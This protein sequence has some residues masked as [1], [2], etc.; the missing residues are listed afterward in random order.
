MSRRSSRK[1]R[2][3]KFNWLAIILLIV[4]VGYFVYREFGSGAGSSANAPV[5]RIDLPTIEPNP[6]S[7]V[8]V[9]PNQRPTPASN[10]KPEGWYDIYFTTPRY[11]DKPEYHHGSLDERL[12]AFI[13]TATKTIDLADYDFDLQNVAGALAQAA[14]RGVRVRMVTDTDTLTNKDKAIQKAFA[15]LKQAKPAAPTPS[16]SAVMDPSLKGNLRESA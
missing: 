13:G 5:P 6:P 1:Q 12:V 11:P 4:L 14:G 9:Q 3:P 10:Q 16:S 8:A 2:S 7:P 15:T